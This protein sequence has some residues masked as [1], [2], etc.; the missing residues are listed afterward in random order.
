MG[1]RMG[2]QA[3]EEY[4]IET[5]SSGAFFFFFLFLFVSHYFAVRRLV[6]YYGQDGGGEDGPRI[7]IN[8][9]AGALPVPVCEPDVL[10]SASA[11][12]VRH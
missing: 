11:S 12:S 9:S 4:A 1:G 7:D 3:E 2:R 6:L 5:R 10:S 8:W